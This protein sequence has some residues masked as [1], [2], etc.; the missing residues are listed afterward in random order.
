MHIYT[1]QIC[2]LYI[3]VYCILTSVSF[4]YNVCYWSERKNQLKNKVNIVFNK[5]QQGKWILW[6]K[7]L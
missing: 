3:H 4:L 7:H 6:Y 2:I 5:I 1:L